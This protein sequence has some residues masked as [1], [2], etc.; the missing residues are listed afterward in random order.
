MCYRASRASTVPISQCSI[1]HAVSP[2]SAYGT[3]KAARLALQNPRTALRVLRGKS[4]VFGTER[5][6]MLGGRL[7]PWE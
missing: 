4:M 3:L 7:A 6:G 2:T 1:E 5:D